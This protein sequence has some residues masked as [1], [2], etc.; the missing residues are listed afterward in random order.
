MD[1]LKSSRVVNV[2]LKPNFL[3]G[4]TLNA[5]LDSLAWWSGED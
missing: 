3:S 1:M 4:T 2:R 5:R